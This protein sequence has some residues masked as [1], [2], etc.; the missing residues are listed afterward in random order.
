MFFEVAAVDSLLS[1]AG[2]FNLQFVKY[3]HDDIL[4]DRD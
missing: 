2:T 4:G 3:V 1:T